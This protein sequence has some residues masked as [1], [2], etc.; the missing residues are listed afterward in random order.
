MG[1]VGLN[2]PLRI[3]GRLDEAVYAAFP[4]ISDFIQ[5]EPNAGEPATEKTEV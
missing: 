2:A 5:M 1:A 4:P 3:D